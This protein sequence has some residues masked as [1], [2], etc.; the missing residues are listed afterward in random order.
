[1]VIEKEWF[2]D[3]NLTGGATFLIALIKHA[4]YRLNQKIN[5]P[6][7]IKRGIQEIAINNGWNTHIFWIL[8][9]KRNVDFL[10]KVNFLIRLPK[11][12]ELTNQWIKT[13]SKYKEP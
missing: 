12:R 2:D 4:K 11:P 5:S 3:M 13:D 10:F 8:R 1:M 6:R 9:E 7:D